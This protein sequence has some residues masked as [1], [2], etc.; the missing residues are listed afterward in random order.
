ML[1]LWRCFVS[2]VW[3]LMESPETC[4]DVSGFRILTEFLPKALS[5]ERFQLMDSCRGD[6][7]VGKAP[8]CVLGPGGTSPMH[9]HPVH[10]SQSWALETQASLHKFQSTV[11][12]FAPM[13]TLHISSLPPRCF[14]NLLVE[15]QAYSLGTLA[16]FQWQFSTTKNTEIQQ[17][18]VNMNRQ[19]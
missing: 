3:V 1:L 11:Q 17:E 7:E 4:Y 10:F 15:A 19:S 12:P 9:T 8:C 18:M 16:L 2:E 13:Q 6:W 5:S 14:E